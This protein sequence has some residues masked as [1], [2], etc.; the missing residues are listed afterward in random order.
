[1]QLKNLDKANAGCAVV[2]AV[3]PMITTMAIRTI[4]IDFNGRIPLLLHCGDVQTD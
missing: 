3:K 4:A 2:I 1:M